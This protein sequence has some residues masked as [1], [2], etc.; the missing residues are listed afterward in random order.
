[1]FIIGEL[2]NGMYANIARAI[3]EKDGAVIQQCARAQVSAGAEALDV[4]CGPASKEPLAD[5]EWLV[6]CIE[7]ATDKAL[8]LD[9]SKPAVIE[10]GLKSAKNKT[11]INSTTADPEKLKIM[12]PLAKQYHAGLIG[13]AIS[14]KGIPQNKNQRLELAAAIVSACVEEG[15]PVEELY[16]DPIVL[17]VKV[18]QA[19]QTD[20]LESI[21]EFKIICEPP[22]KTIVGLSNVSQGAPAANRSLINR[23]FLVMAAAFGLDAAIIDP[24]DKEL[25][26]GLISAE[27]LLNKH[28]YCDSY[29][30][31]YRRR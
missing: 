14:S 15:F 1:M 9:S 20:I 16:L 13:L 30:E 24:T 4:N 18:A 25:M 5:I 17:P 21:R 27:L 3:K 28:I 29:L 7:E 19:Q 10:A 12:I 22:L 6:H 23:T 31:A 11:V 8:V 2:I 26:Q